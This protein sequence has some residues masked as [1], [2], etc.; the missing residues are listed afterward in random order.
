MMT[1]SAKEK[2]WFLLSDLFVDTDHPERELREMAVALKRTGFS[3][4]E[5]EKILHHEVAPVCGRWM[6]YGG[7]I[8]LWPMFDQAALKQRIHKHLVRPWYK[9]PLVNT[10]LLGLSSVQRDWEIVRD[11]M[12]NQDDG[13]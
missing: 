8:G 2:V 9:P 12:E 1:E 7:A 10:G 3:T 11:A 6:R 5:V 4:D 13:I